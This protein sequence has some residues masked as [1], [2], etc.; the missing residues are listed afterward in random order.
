ME[1]KK[2]YRFYLKIFVHIIKN[3]GWKE[4]FKKTKETKWICLPPIEC[5][6]VI[7]DNY[8]KLVDEFDA[9]YFKTIKLDN[10]AKNYIQ[11]KLHNNEKL[12]EDYTECICKYVLIPEDNCTYDEL[13]RRLKF[14]DFMELVR[15]ELL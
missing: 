2:V 1:K 9:K 11:S 3:H 5:E 14:E 4:F 8:Q 6:Y 7:T 10:V 15:Q 13:K 12:E